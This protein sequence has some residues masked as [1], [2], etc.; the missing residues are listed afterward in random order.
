[1]S[2]HTMMHLYYRTL[3]NIANTMDHM[4][5]DFARSLWLN[6]L[7]GMMKNIPY[8]KNTRGDPKIPIT[9]KKN[10]FKIFVQV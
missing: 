1:M 10:L 6:F 8:S 7:Y 5:L 3:T 4:M 2:W 9:V